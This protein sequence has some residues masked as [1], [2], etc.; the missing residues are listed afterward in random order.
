LATCEGSLDILVSQAV[1]HSDSELASTN[2]KGF[3]HV[4]CIQACIHSG[5]GDFLD[6]AIGKSN[7]SPTEC[8][9]REHGVTAVRS[10]RY[11]QVEDAQVFTDLDVGA[12][13]DAA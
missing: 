4:S 2:S 9:R 13:D 10:L 1:D 7:N 3:R 12:R 5:A 8:V 6:Y 11:F